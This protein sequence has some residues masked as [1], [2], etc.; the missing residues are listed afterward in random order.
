MVD[1]VKREFISKHA[2]EGK[3]PFCIRFFR[4]HFDTAVAVQHNVRQDRLDNIAYTRAQAGSVSAESVAQL[5]CC[6]AGNLLQ[7][8]G[9]TVFIIIVKEQIGAMQVECEVLD[10]AKVN[11]RFH[12]AKSIL[13]IVQLVL[14]TFP[15]RTLVEVREFDKNAASSSRLAQCTSGESSGAKST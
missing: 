1:T 8:C 7:M 3:Q 11:I 9:R 4:N 12:M 2:F 10:A 15:N 6:Q 13:Q 5:A 14:D